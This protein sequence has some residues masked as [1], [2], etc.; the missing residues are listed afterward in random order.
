M[1]F[2]FDSDEV[3]KEF[4]ITIT[5]GPLY[6]LLLIILYI[7]IFSIFC[8]ISFFSVNNLLLSEETNINY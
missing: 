7:I 3:I 2:E 6:E 5:K 8:F 4:G 1:S